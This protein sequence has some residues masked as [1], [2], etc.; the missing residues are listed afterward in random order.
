MDEMSFTRSYAPA[1]LT[2]LTLV[3]AGVIVESATPLELGIVESVVLV[4]TEG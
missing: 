1:F 2:W 3:C 4:M